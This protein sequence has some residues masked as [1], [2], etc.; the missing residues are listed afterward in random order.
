MCHRAVL[1]FAFT[2]CSSFPGCGCSCTSYE[3]IMMCFVHKNRRT[4]CTA[5]HLMAWKSAMMDSCA[6]HWTY[7][8]DCGMGCTAPCFGGAHPKQLY[9]YDSRLRGCSQLC[10]CQ[11][12]CV[13]SLALRAACCLLQCP[14]SIEGTTGCLCSN[15]WCEHV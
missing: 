3:E 6:C 5:E 15:T 1:T 10:K 13:L 2:L 14:G 7:T 12:T 11:G 4:T 8:I 9:A